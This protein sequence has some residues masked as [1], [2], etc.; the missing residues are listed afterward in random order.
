MI[1]LTIY[2]DKNTK[3]ALISVIVPVYNVEAFLPKCLES[4]INQTYKNIEIILVDDGS[5]DNSGKICDFYKIQDKRIKVIHKFNGGISSARNYGLKVI[6]GEYILFVDSD[7]W[8]DENHIQTLA[9]YTNK[10]RIVC[11]G[12]KRIIGNN[13]I[14]HCV[15]NI[16]KCNQ[17]EFINV[18]QDY[19]IKRLR[20]YLINPIGNYMW[21]KIFP[22]WIFKDIE[23]LENQA[24]EDMYIS[25]KLYKKI[26]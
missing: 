7:D 20:K 3:E 24:Y 19:E 11:C 16:L 1:L 21:N 18:L 2:N 5:T 26:K 17:S 22:T 4:I 10:E 23:F 14:T 15:E 12:Y 13:I 25:L 9:L 6:R 8:L